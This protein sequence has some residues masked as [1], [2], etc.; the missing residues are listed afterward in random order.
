MAYITQA[1][2]ASG[3]PPQFLLEALDD[4]GDGEIDAGLWDLVEAE[5]AEAIDGTLGQRFTVPFTAPLPAVVKRAAR[6]FVLELL[7]K[8]RGTAAA[9][10]PWAKEADALRAKLD[11]I[12]DGEEPLS[13]GAN[14][15]N[16]SVTVVKEAAR[17]TAANE[18][19]AC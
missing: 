14:K 13:P 9:N 6:V 2:I 4:D 16:E 19:L 12:A 11:R 1:E 18:N 17:T 8:R 10:N 15:T 3:L 5:A 7:Y